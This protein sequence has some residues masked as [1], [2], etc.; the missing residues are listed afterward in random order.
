MSDIPLVVFVDDE[1]M[2]HQLFKISFKQEIRSK[3]FNLKTFLNGKECLDYLEKS[4]SDISILFL[5]TDINMP[6]V[7][8]MELLKEIKDK[9]PNIEVYMASAY[10]GEDYINQ[11]MELGASD[12]FVKPIDF[13]NIRKIISNKIA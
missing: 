2:M 4:Y 12:Y 13:E 9:Y 10:S 3:L 8:G 7:N 1:E 6:V 11:S 5:I